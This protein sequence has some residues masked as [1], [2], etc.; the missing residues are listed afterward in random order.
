MNLS[1]MV[2]YK[3]RAMQGTTILV[4]QSSEVSIVGETFCNLSKVT[5]IFETQASTAHTSYESL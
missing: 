2:S 3:Y 4:L 5:I 1:D